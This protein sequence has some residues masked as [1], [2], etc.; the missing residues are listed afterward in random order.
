MSLTLRNTNVG[1]LSAEPYDVCIVGGGINGAVSAAALAA[2][3]VSVALIDR[4]DFAGETSSQSSNLAWGGI[5]YMETLEFPLVWNLCESR[6]HLVSKL[7]IDGSGDS[8]SHDHREGLSFSALV[9]LFGVARL[10]G[11]GAFCHAAT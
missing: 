6:N 3:G 11:D 9:R 1:K 2:Q 10:L 8:L 7:P 4:G 5:K